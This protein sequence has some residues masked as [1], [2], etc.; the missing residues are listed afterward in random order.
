M[1]APYIPSAALELIP[2]SIKRANESVAGPVIL[3]RGAGAGAGGWSVVEIPV[4]Q[5]AA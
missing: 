1:A 3:L 5:D 4:G 2:V